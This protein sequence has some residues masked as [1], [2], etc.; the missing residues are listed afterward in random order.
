MKPGGVTVHWRQKIRNICQDPLLLPAQKF[1]LSMNNKT[2]N[3]H[4]YQYG[5]LIGRGAGC[6]DRTRR[7]S[8]CRLI[9]ARPRKA[10]GVYLKQ[11]TCLLSPPETRH[12]LQYEFRP[13]CNRPDSQSGHKVFGIIS[14]VKMK[15]HLK[16]SHVAY[17][18]CLASLLACIDERL[19]SRAAAGET[20][21]V[22]GLR[23]LDALVPCLRP[24]Y[25][26]AHKTSFFEI[27][28]GI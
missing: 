2:P 23:L 21:R 6:N 18:A 9:P 1:C 12:I 8:C 25:R 20:E 7:T 14:G 17:T 28:T 26:I 19:T 10:S 27:S 3:N 11:I 13:V 24:Y 15:P 5:W 4:G 16:L 22:A